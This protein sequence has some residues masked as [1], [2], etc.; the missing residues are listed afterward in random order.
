M[1]RGREPAEGR[2]DAGKM[3]D[4]AED[5][6]KVR[7][8]ARGRDAVRARARGKAEDAGKVR[9]AP[10]QGRFLINSWAGVFSEMG[11]NS[12]C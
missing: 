7:A 12:R 11:Q 6:A 10:H 2:V 9:A 4:P 5:V 3:A 1:E 8:R